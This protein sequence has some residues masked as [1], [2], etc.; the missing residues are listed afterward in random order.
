VSADVV[1]RLR[2]APGLASDAV[3][4]CVA[5]LDE[6][7]GRLVEATRTL[8]PA[9]LCWQLRPG[10]N[11]I[12]MLLAHVAVAETHIGQVGL[13]RERDGHVHDVLGITVEDE[14]LP[15][16]PGGPPA[17]ALTGRDSA[18]FA[19]LLARAGAHTRRA[20]AGLGDAELDL[21]IVRPPRPDGTVRIFTRRWLLFH[22]VEHAAGHLGQIQLLRHLLPPEV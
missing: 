11:T 22:M 18:F 15:L 10:T 21:D 7:R 1:S 6:L 4:T 20:A 3:A 12:G 17:P 13:L 14:G 9:Q 5:E 16:A 2:P 19:D 8:T